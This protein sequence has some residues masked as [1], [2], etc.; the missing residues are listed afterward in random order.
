MSHHSLSHPLSDQSSVSLSGY[1]SY[2]KQKPVTKT[3]EKKG[4]TLSDEVGGERKDQTGQ[5]VVTYSYSE[6]EMVFDL[7]ADYLHTRINQSSDY[8]DYRTYSDEISHMVRVR[9]KYSLT[10]GESGGKVTIGGDYSDDTYG[11]DGG[12]AC[13]ADA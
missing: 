4:S 9:P 11:R 2:L 10:L 5:A 8:A 1:Y 3:G 7:T 13:D 6:E 12:A